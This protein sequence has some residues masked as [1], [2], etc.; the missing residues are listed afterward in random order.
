[1]SPV[2]EDSSSAARR[3]G[4]PTCSLLIITAVWLVI[5]AG[6][7]FSPALLDDADSVH[8]EAAREILLRHDWVTLHID[9]LRYLEKAPLMYWGIASSFLTFGVA[10]W[11]ARLPLVLGVLASLLAVYAFG[12]KAYGEPGGFWS[13]MVMATAIGPYLFTRFLIP[14]V[15]VGLWLTLTFLFFLETLKDDA[16]SRLACWGMAAATALNVLTK[17]LIGV[18]FPIA[19][20]GLFLLVTGNLK[21]LLRLRLVS[22][23]LVFLAIGAPWHILAALRNPDQGGVRGFLWFYFVN[24]HFMR[25]LNKRIPR[26]YDTVPFLVFWGLLL[27][28]VF[29]WSAFLPQ[30][31]R[32]VPWRHLRSRLTRA[33]MANLLCLLWALVILVFFSF[34]SRQE[35]YTIPALP[36]L[37]LLVGGWLGRTA[38]EHNA[39]VRASLILFVIGSVAAVA[40]FVVLVLS[41]PPPP[42]V[43]L[44]SL[45]NMR[46]AQDY[47]LSFDHIFDLTPQAFG[48]FRAPLLGT[49]LGLFAGTGLNWWL[50]RRNLH[51]AGNYALA[52]MMMVLLFCV[53]SAL[54]TFSPILSSKQL[55]LA[56]KPHLAPSDEVVIDGEYEQGSTLNFYL[57]VPVRVLHERSA[58]LYYGS[59]FPDAPDV[60]ETQE[61][62]LRLWDGPRRVFLWTSE[63]DPKALRNASSFLVAHSGGKSVF[64][65]QPL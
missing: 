58:N 26:D 48:M 63:K 43:E 5:Y 21:H 39:G 1:M 35:Y 3:P 31:L 20:I 40:A 37:A 24:E 23:T 25:Y 16:P 18:V 14:D 27:V 62:F 13:A 57:G 28:W 53:H 29:P 2:R 36:A 49:A 65:N 59:L 60:F 22:S 52:G 50:R 55:A 30:A 6:S 56:I 51:R 44:A 41:Q 46:S 8:A 15:L 47:A 42:G 9:G 33:Q 38:K 4:R 64:T 11:S 61:T 10:E 7:I 12:R 32:E 17:G 19:V 45:L 54:V 34:S